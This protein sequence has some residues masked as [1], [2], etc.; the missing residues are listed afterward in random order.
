M[1]Q[2]WVRVAIVNFN[3]ASW[4]QKAVD[5]LGRQAFAD[6]EAVI[7]DNASSD[8][9]LATLKLPDARFSVLRLARNLGF[10]AANNLA[11]RNCRAPWLATLNPDAFPEPDWLDQLHL[12]VA[13]HPDVAMFGS[14]QIDAIDR[15]T[16]DGCGDCYSVF[17]FPWRGG[18]GQPLSAAPADDI[19]VFAPCAAAALY[20]RDAYESAGGFDE[21]FFCYLEDV[22]LGFRLRLLGHRC[23]QLRQALVYHVG[24]ALSGRD[25]AFTL[26]QSYRNRIWL[27]VKDVPF[28]LVLLMLPYHVAICLRDIF[29]QRGTRADAAP[30]KGLVAGIA[31]AP[32][33][34]VARWAIQRAR[35]VGWRAI[36][37]MLAWET[38]MM[39]ER[40][41]IALG[42]DVARGAVE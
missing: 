36:A 21:R 33:Q 35:R 6:F 19:E 5:A 13:R 9:S 11:F 31:G 10:A 2:P 14:T 28:P 34:L 29:R 4:L 1:T 40:R 7:V 18:Q 30:L 17:G 25:S 16:L 32:R 39:A 38:Q 27:I 20:R 37:S 24:S 23:V 26:F 42:A 22:D 41:V 3:G 12:G 15:G 8:D